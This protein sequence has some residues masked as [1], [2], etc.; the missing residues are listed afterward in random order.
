LG[1]LSIMAAN[2]GWLNYKQQ[3]STGPS[4]LGLINWR[5][6]IALQHSAALSRNLNQTL[7]IPFLTTLND[8]RQ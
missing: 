1:L 2:V 7:A 5:P 4:Q 8:D 6:L 3:R